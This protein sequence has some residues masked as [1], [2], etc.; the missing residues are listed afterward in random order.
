[1]HIPSWASKEVRTAR[2][3]TEQLAEL[4][5]EVLTGVGKTG[6]VGLLSGAQPGERT[7]LLRFDMDA[8]PIEEENDAP[9]RSQQ[10]PARTHACGHDAHV[11]GGIGVAT[12]LARHREQ[13]GGTIKL[14]FQ[15]AEEGLGGACAM[16][17]DWLLRGPDVDVALGL[18]VLVGPPGWHGGGAQRRAA[19]RLGQAAGS[20]V[21]GRGGH[22]AQRHQ[23]VDAVAGQLCR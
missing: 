21:Q 5:Y 10:T 9:Y 13:F 2:V 6:V 18:H 11:A 23:T 12:L 22:A 8:L 15:P 7:V 16:I 1:M 17:A 3:V 20:V 4:G 19:G 14:M